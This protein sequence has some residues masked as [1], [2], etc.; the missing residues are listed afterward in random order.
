MRRL[1]LGVPAAFLALASLI[2]LRE[3]ALAAL[4]PCL[5]ALLASRELRA[6]DSNGQVLWQTPDG[7]H[8]RRGRADRVGQL[9]CRA[10]LDDL[11]WLELLPHD[12]RR[13]RSQMLLFRGAVSA[14][15]WSLLR[16]RLRLDGL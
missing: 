9:R 7:W 16:R 15:S 12:C 10:R 2:A 6:L 5:V 3:S 4:G 14:R 1:C 13:P 11:L 8:W